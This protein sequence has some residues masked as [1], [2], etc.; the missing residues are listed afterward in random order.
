MQRSSNMALAGAAVGGLAL[1]NVASDAFVAAPTLGAPSLRGTNAAPTQ[2]QSAPSSGAMPALACGGAVAVAAVASQRAGRQSRTSSLPTSVVPCQAVPAETTEYAATS[3]Q[4]AWD[5]H[6]EAFGEQ[7]LEKIMLD[8]DETS[9]AKVYNSVDGSKT[10]FVGVQE[11]RE[12]FTKLFEDLFDLKTLEAPVVE[13]DESRKT[14]FLVWKCPG[15]GFATAT[16]TFVFGP[17]FKIKSQHIV[18]AREAV[19]DKTS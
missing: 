15:C 19:K 2:V 11:I 3:V 17:D 8:Y 9:I 16:D 5:N 4:A 10:D 6:F 1:L 7:D 18:V 12:M 13:V 14:V